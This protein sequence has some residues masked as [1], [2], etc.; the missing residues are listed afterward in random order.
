MH[1][2][3]LE[4]F[5]VFYFMRSKGIWPNDVTFKGIL[6]ACAHEGLVEFGLKYFNMTREQFKLMPK[7]E[8]FGCMVNLRGRSRGS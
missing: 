2:R 7:V 3:S 8:Y 6:R 1:G 5:E 4:A